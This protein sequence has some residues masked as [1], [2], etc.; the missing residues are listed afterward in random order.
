LTYNPNQ[1][2]TTYYTKYNITRFLQQAATDKGSKSKKLVLHLD[3]EGISFVE[4][5]DKIDCDVIRDSFKVSSTHIAQTHPPPL[6]RDFWLN[7]TDHLSFR[8]YLTYNTISL[9]KMLFTCIQVTFY[10]AE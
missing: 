6:K 2:T 9:N 4:Q 8:S 10:S 7:F 5:P 1:S 3:I